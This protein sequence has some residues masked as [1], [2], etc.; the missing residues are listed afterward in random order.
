MAAPRRI[1]SLNRYLSEDGG[2]GINAFNRAKEA[3]LTNNQIFAWLSTWDGNIGGLVRQQMARYYD[4]RPENS[5]NYTAAKG[6]R[7]AGRNGNV[8]W[9]ELQSIAENTGK[10]TAQVVRQLDRLNERRDLS[11]GLGSGAVKNL[12]LTPG[13]AAALPWLAGIAGF[14]AFGTGKIGTTLGQYANAL[15]K[16][17][18]RQP[19]QTTRQAMNLRLTEA[20]LV[21]LNGGTNQINAKGYYVPKV[22]TTPFLQHQFN[23]FS[24]AQA[25]APAPA[26]EQTEMMAPIDGG[27]G[28]GPEISPMG[29]GLTGGGESNDSASYLRKKKSRAERLG[30]DSMGTAALQRDRLGYANTFGR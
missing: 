5:P 22:T 12:A 26:P 7:Q 19:G 9:N 3:G 29:S 21:P 16:P 4:Q 15:A 13:N 27:G 25:P 10:T 2:F 11:I 6:L 18:Q 23:K 8:S 30:I 17:L 28:G 24:G 1:P 14:N 20:G